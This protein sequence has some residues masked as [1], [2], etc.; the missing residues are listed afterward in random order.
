MMRSCTCIS[1]CA[2][3]IEMPGSV[4]GMYSSVPSSS[5]GMNSLPSR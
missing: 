1:R 2:S 3:L 5:G 4:E